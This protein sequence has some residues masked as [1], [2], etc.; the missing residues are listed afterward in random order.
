VRS[1]P[2]RE[3]FDLMSVSSIPLIMRRQSDHSIESEDD[4]LNTDIQS[5]LEGRTCCDKL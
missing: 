4:E 2:G 1:K 5:L 3:G